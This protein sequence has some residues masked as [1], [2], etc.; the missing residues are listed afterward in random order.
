M[1]IMNDSD[2]RG[3]LEGI[4]TDDQLY[5]WAIDSGSSGDGAK[6]YIYVGDQLYAVVT[7]D[8]FREDLRQAGINDG[9][10]GFTVSVDSVLRSAQGQPT[11]IH[12]YLDKERQ[13]ELENSPVKTSTESTE[14]NQPVMN[15]DLAGWTTK[16]VNARKISCYFE[17]INNKG[18]IYGWACDPEDS[19]YKPKVYLFLDEFPLGVCMANQF[20]ADLKAAGIAHGMAGFNMG[21]NC[22]D[23]SRLKPDSRVR[24][25][26]DVEARHELTNS[27]L[28]INEDQYRNICISTDEVRIK[29]LEGTFEGLNEKG[30]VSG[31]ALDPNDVQYKPVVYLYSGGVPVGSMEASQY[32]GDLKEA[33]LGDG[34]CAFKW[35]NFTLEGLT[36]IKKNLSLQAYYDLARTREL[37]GSPVKIT[38]ALA[39]QVWVVIWNTKHI[40]KITLT[41]KRTLLQE[42][43]SFQRYDKTDSDMGIRSIH[44][45]ALLICQNLYKTK[46]FSELVNMFTPAWLA[47]RKED[48][49]PAFDFHLYRIM[50]QTARQQL[51]QSQLDDFER[52]FYKET[53]FLLKSELSTEPAESGWLDNGSSTHIEGEI[54]TEN[55]ESDNPDLIEL[56]TSIVKVSKST[57]FKSFLA[58]RYKKYL[59]PSCL[60]SYYQMILEFQS[61]NTTDAQYRILLNKY[62]IVMARTLSEVYDDPQLALSFLGILAKDEVI[63]KTVELYSLTGRISQQLG[64]NHDA[65]QYYT[66]ATINGSTW[67]KVYHEA[68]LIFSIIC[69]HQINLYRQYTDDIIRLLSR[70][71]DFN[72]Q[73]S[74]GFKLAENFVREFIETSITHTGNLS[75]TEETD[76]ALQER[77]EDL[78]RAMNAIDNFNTLIHELCQVPETR[79]SISRQYRTVVFVA[80]QSLW[81]C[82]YYRTKQKLDHARVLGWNTRY[83]DMD[84]LS[85]H[86]KSKKELLYSDVL[87][88]CRAP[89]TYEVL[90]LISYARSL[91][92]P[93]IYDID[94][95]IFDERYFPSPLATYAGT[96]DTD[97][98]QHLRMDNPLHR[99]GL[100]QAD[101]VTCSTEPLAEQ[102]RNLPGF[103]KPVVIY[104]NL[105][106][107]E[108]ALHARNHKQPEVQNSSE[109]GSIEIFYGSATKAHKQVF[110]EVLCPA[111]SVVLTRYPNVK[112]TLIGYFKL[113]RSLSGLVERIRIIEPSPNYMGYINR[114][115]Q[116]HINIAVLEQD[117]FT[118]C[119]SEL[120]W[121]EAGAFG[122]PSVV[123]PTATYRHVLTPEENV[124]FATDTNEWIQQLS[125][126]V[127]SDTLRRDIGLKAKADTFERYHPQVGIRIL[128]QLLNDT[129]VSPLPE[130]RKIKLLFVN[131]FF[132]P[133]SVGGATRI[134]ESHVRYLLE[135]Y[136]DDYEIQILTTE[137]DP[138]HWQPYSV[139]QYRYG[140]ALVTK[141]RIP[142]REWADYEDEQVYSFCQEFYR[143]NGFDLI[144]FHSIQVLTASVVDVA[145]EMKIPY[146]ITLHDGWWLSRY[147]F[148]MDENGKEIDPAD[149]FSGSN[150]END[151]LLW[152]LERKNR[153]YRAMNEAAWVL[154]VSD[155]FRL[156]HEN[157]VTSGRLRTNENGMELFDVLPREP[158]SSN[159][160]RVWHLGGMSFHKGF[161]I[162]REAIISARFNNLEISIIDHALEPGE[163]YHDLWGTTPVRFYAKVKQSE[164]N[165]LYAR[166]DVL[167]APSLWPESFGLVTREAL[168]AG[169]WVI[170]SDR[171]AVGDA[172]TD[173]QNGRVVD[174]GSPAGLIAALKEID[175]APL[176]FSQARESVIPRPVS[177]QAEECI[178]LYKELTPER[179]SRG[180]A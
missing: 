168:Y 51:D 67:W 142:A 83:L 179:D 61:H 137:Y 115:R 119:K 59:R 29:R 148:L 170:A 97:L 146:L 94:D 34:K 48:L 20:R 70:G 90:E 100:L 72:P 157:S 32:R 122:I 81:Q 52:D 13:I 91:K 154:A 104:P 164:V 102:I 5:G 126:L 167:V 116:A 64:L 7:A 160:I 47:N 120:K 8:Q 36:A 149:P 139:V 76:R 96:I 78:N 124:L 43:L 109:P 50:A 180:K 162:L 80:S 92:I 128:E 135:H 106:S 49:R 127:A 55:T 68:G 18:D 129:A 71:L 3:Y 130:Q 121:F 54:V 73:Q 158:A 166:M 173:R 101:I 82:F 169:V 87:Y 57:T 153:L 37:S 19:G 141:L 46:E 11:D 88:I 131:V 113:P 21:F 2:K 40:D 22:Q 95:L 62:I 165:A 133:Q 110:Y 38:K 123:T 31:W 16:Q 147:L 79:S 171:G 45:I 17:G 28:N 85:Q 42:A 105:L 178:A 175:E 93:I 117:V 10:A 84:D 150:A 156:L 74:A 12:A 138:A 174:V 107:D 86:S 60:E 63:E 44:C 65:L 69:Q 26:L 145:R 151:D 140:A 136:P 9:K 176:S 98:H 108:L 152:L 89:A 155:K 99:I 4:S 114:L 27:P 56:K 125:R 163:T 134:V 161:Y 24:A 6:V 15:A 53:E 1:N 103:D 41:N 143:R 25:Y 132:A 39:Q 58:T 14:A 111:L 30:D 144:H 118:D 172:I 75:T 23:I 77:H 35:N 66:Q 33:E 177:E 112:L 159:R